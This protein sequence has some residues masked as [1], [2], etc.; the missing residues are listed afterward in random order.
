LAESFGGCL[1]LRIAAAAPHLL[2][3]LVLLNPATCYNQS[4]N[5]LSSLV[6]AT[7]LLGLFPQDLYNTAQVRRA[8]HCSGCCAV[9]C[10]GRRPSLNT[11]PTMCGVAAPRGR[12]LVCVQAVLLPLLVDIDRVGPEGAHALRSMIF[13]EPPPNFET[14]ASQQADDDAEQQSVVTLASERR[15]LQATSGAAFTTSGPQQRL[16]ARPGSPGVQAMLGALGMSSS[17]GGGSSGSGGWRSSS[18]G[19]AR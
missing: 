11:L 8:A 18:R 3:H 13:M 6:S 10:G 14:A 2:K 7:N 19:G 15:R 5:G 9:R 17:G 4:L 1:A 16:A 12:A